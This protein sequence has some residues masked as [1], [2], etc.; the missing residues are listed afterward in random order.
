MN[1][2][3]HSTRLQET[4]EDSPTPTGGD[5]GL[6]RLE[7]VLEAM[8]APSPDIWTWGTVL[9]RYCLLM[10]PGLAGPGFNPGSIR[11]SGP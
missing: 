8:T 5:R 10:I 7:W 3:I 9:S 1:P 2:R 11:G 6:Q 4:A